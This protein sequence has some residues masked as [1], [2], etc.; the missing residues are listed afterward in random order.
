MLLFIESV[1]SITG[2]QMA[3]WAVGIISGQGV[4]LTGSADKTIKAWKAGKCIQT[5]NGN[6]ILRVIY[7]K[8]C[9]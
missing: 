5:Y 8:H 4:M 6:V 1:S 7:T 3:V 9:L 2:H